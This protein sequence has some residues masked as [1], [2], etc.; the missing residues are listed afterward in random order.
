MHKLS[1]EHVNTIDLLAQLDSQA[2]NKAFNISN[3]LGL[4]LLSSSITDYSNFLEKKHGE[5]VLSFCGEYRIYIT[6]LLE[7][8]DDKYK[9]S[10]ISE[11]ISPKVKEMTGMEFLQIIKQATTKNIDKGKI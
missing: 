4:G 7:K 11:L 9:E 2:I 3:T 1:S 6:K 8:I 5:I 10:V